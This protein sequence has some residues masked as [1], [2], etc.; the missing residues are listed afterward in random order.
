[1]LGTRALSSPW[2][3]VQTEQDG[4]C[5]AVAAWVLLPVGCGSSCK[6]W[7]PGGARLPG[8][9]G[10]GLRAASSGFLHPAMEAA[11]VAQ[12]HVGG[13]NSKAQ[14]PSTVPGTRWDST[15]FLSMDGTPRKTEFYSV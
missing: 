8:R 1:M 12:W 6:T 2:G 5:L 4:R 13:P 14:T 3:E 15:T 10:A 9:E 11:A 7:V